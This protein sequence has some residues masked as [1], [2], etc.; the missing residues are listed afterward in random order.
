MAT[1]PERLSSV[2]TV[3]WGLRERAR[4]ETTLWPMAVGVGGGPALTTKYVWSGSSRRPFG[5]VRARP[6]YNIGSGWSMCSDWVG[7]VFL[8]LD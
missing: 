6:M 2:A 7:R 5:M 1:W 3:W 8:T 4:G